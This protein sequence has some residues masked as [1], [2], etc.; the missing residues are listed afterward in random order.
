[1]ASVP[2]WGADPMCQELVAAESTFI[3]SDKFSFFTKSRNKASAIGERQMFP[4]QTNKTLIISI[5]PF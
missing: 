5:S 4:K 2:L 3:W 1:M